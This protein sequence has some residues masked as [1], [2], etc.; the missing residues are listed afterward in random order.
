MKRIL[1]ALTLL[2]T[3]WAAPAHA[4]QYKGFYYGA[5]SPQELA[6]IVERAIARDPTGKTMLDAAKCRRDGSCAAPINYVESM[7]THDPYGNWSLENL[8]EKMR[9]LR[10]DCTV[11]GKYQMDRII[12]TSGPLGSTD[13]NGMSRAFKRN[14]CAWVNPETGAPVL[15]QDCANP[16]GQ[17]IDVDCV[18]I[19]FQT[20]IPSERMV[21]WQRRRSAT[22]ECFAY[23]RV[24]R[25]YESQ[26]SGPSWQPIRA[27]DLNGPCSFCEYNRAFGYKG[28]ATGSIR[29]EVGYHQ[30]R[31]ARNE[32]IDL[33]LKSWDH[34][35]V[36]SSFTNGMNWPNEYSL[37][38]REHHAR[39]F[40]SSDEMEAAGLLVGQPKARL[41]W[42]SNAAAEVRIHESYRRQ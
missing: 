18:V 25:I 6:T 19:N 15:A 31:I 13:I 27:N 20:T 4:S 33:C 41:W 23:R 8:V 5:K 3:M 39:V 7:R 10:L 38:G 14:E 1:I 34:G 17:R 35:Q 40:Y 29:L 21:D 11:T 36:R 26:F 42:A 22:D 16:V 28:V 9:G 2:I 12:W 30:I 32:P 37:K 24:S